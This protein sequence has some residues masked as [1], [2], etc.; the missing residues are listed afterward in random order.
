[1]TI[2]RIGSCLFLLSVHAMQDAHQKRLISVHASVEL[3]HYEE[4][5]L[6]NFLT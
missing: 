1:M 5:N 3:K 4:P 6:C 2:S